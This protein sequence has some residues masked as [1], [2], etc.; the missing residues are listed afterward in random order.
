MRYITFAGDGRILANTDIGE[1]THALNL[2]VNWLA[3]MKKKFRLLGNYRLQ[4]NTIV[5][6]SMILLCD[7]R[8]R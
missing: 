4:A 3:G 5:G 6:R 2:I 1:T 8:H 7:P